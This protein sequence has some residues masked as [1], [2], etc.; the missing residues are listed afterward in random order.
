MK[1]KNTSQQSTDLLAHFNEK[2]QVCFTTQEAA[3][4]LKST[5]PK[6]LSELLSGMSRRGLLMKIKHGIYYIIPYEQKPETFMPD[7]HRLAQY[8]VGDADYYIGYY[9]AMQIHSLITQP[10]LKEQIVVNKQLKPSSLLIKGI[11]F[12]FIYHN[13]KHFFGNK[14]TWVDSFNKV[15]CSDLEK[16][17]IDALFKPQYAGGITE[18]AKALY[19]SKEKIDYKKLLNYAAQFDS[20]AVSKRLGYLLELLQ[21]EQP[22]VQSLQ[23]LKTKS[24]FLLEPSH[25]KD[26]K[27]ISRWNLHEN[28]DHQSVLS[29][30]FS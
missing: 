8:I 12:Q 6:A 20:L 24:Y 23:K 7:W 28:I 19:K 11:P 25:S 4:A 27:M 14:K 15:Q 2:E 16:T 10:A 30:I 9:S 18:I 17:F 1:S 29:L 26:G 22:M 21:I 13:E 3:R 5:K